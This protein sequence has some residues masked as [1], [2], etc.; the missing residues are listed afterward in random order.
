MTVRRE[1]LV[2]LAV[3]ATLAV[4]MS[5]RGVKAMGDKATAWKVIG[6]IVIDGDLSEWNKSSPIAIDSEGQL[7]R[8][9][10]QW[11]GPSDLSAE[12]YLM[13]DESNLYVGAEVTDGSPFMSRT[14]FSI[15]SLDSMG[16]YL[17]TNPDAD[18][19]RE[20][21]ESTDFRVL[22]VID[23]DS[24]YT[25][26]D[27]D[28]VSD[29]KGIETDGMY[30][31]KNVLGGYEVA[32]GGFEGG[33]TFEA[34]IPFS[35]FYNNQ[36]P[37][38]IPTAGMEVGFDVELNDLDI[39]CPESAC[40]RMAWRG[41][42]D[43]TGSPKEWGT[44]KFAHLASF[45]HSTPSPEVGDTVQFTDQSSGTVVSWYWSFG[46]GNSSTE[47]N[48]SHTYAEEGTYT[49]T[50]TVTDSDGNTDTVSATVNVTGPESA[51]GLP[52]VPIAVVAGV[53]VIILAVV[54]WKR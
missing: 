19:A 37:E 45:S 51:P 54:A 41:D 9:A 52:I 34:K 4:V 25:G 35:N 53:V 8:A 46:D 15:D 48:P 20:L 5:A 43:I 33:Y 6:P 27:R 16:L 32:V 23:N 31:G 11:D 24:F 17:S 3:L 29:S 2:L 44:L 21:Y 13:W 10:S 40:V 26:I 28:M 18:P 39:P 22:L 14:G 7:I 42:E 50:L 47:Q 49:V 12:V 36:L 1:L 38:F 30:G